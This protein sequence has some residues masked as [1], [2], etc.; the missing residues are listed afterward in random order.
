MVT[1]G[2]KIRALRETKKMTQ[3]DLAKVLN[4]T[5]QAIS[6]WELDKSY[7][8][9]DTLLKLS[10]YFKVS[11]DEILGNGKDSFFATLFA[12]MKGKIEMD[13]SSNENLPKA[14]EVQVMA[15]TLKILFDNGT[16][17]Y[18]K[19]HALQEGLKTKN[20]QTKSIPKF[21]GTKIVIEADGTVIL[22]DTDRYTRT[23]LWQ[24]SVLKID[25]NWGF[26]PFGEVLGVIQKIFN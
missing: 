24:E 18:L 19:S 22:N 6:K 9:L 4:V 13:K 25:F 12:K 11:T 14:E 26:L 3:K 21:I 5:P 23:E 1:I 7:P 17:K 2:K 20:Q 15:G 8:D 10:Q 16:E